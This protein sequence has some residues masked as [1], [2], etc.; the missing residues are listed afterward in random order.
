MKEKLIFKPAQVFVFDENALTSECV[1][2]FEN[3]VKDHKSL[4]IQFNRSKAFSKQE[5]FLLN[6]MKPYF[7][8]RKVKTVLVGALTK[9]N[10]DL[11]NLFYCCEKKIIYSEET[12]RVLKSNT[13]VSL[14]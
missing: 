3:M 12:R 1:R 7:L 14:L 10:Q 8:T 6:M 5:R 9:G 13:V 11:M 2:R 4:L